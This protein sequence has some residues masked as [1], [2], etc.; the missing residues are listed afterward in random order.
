[1]ATDRA[2]TTDRKLTSDSQGGAA[3]PLWSLDN[4]SRID[5][6]F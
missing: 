6:A 1:M 2:R 4:G 3:L 5:G